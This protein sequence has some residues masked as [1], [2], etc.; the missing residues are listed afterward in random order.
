MAL[1]ADATGVRERCEQ[2]LN[3]PRSK[4]S[5]DGFDLAPGEVFRGRATSGLSVATSE[6]QAAGP[7]GEVNFDFDSGAGDIAAGATEIAPNLFKA[8]LRR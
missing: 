8:T 7:N 5:V 2:R 4:V 1:D 6:A 3:P